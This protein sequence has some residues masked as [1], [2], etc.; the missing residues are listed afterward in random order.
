MAMTVSSIPMEVGV[1]SALSF[2]SMSSNMQSIHVTLALLTGG[3]DLHP[4]QATH[5]KCLLEGVL[6]IRLPFTDSSAV[7]GD[8]ATPIG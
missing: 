3:A 2:H 7:R 1:R 6:P 8:R 5:A 4:R